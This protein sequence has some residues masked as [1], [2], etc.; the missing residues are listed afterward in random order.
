M[1][2]YKRMLMQLLSGS[3]LDQWNSTLKVLT[4]A[5]KRKII[6]FDYKI[7]NKYLE[8]VDHA[9]Y[10]G[11]HHISKKFLWKYHVSR[12]TSNANH[13][14]HFLQR[15]LVTCNRETKL[16]CYKRSICPIVEYA[17]QFGIL[18]GTRNF[19]TN[20]NR[21]KRKQH[22]GLNPTGIIKVVLVIWYRTWIP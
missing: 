22:G 6:I 2:L 4:I 12:I 17:S 20:L 5:N 10:L 21:C 7:H 18:L 14:R 3:K 15:N 16:Q 19:S 8:K 13:C 11:V 9:K 1:Q